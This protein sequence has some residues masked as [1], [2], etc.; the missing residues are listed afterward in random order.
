MHLTHYIPN[1]IISAY[2]QDNEICHSLLF[3]SFQTQHIR[4]RLSTQLATFKCPTATCGCHATGPPA[5]RGAGV[6]QPGGDEGFAVQVVCQEI[7]RHFQTALTRKIPRSRVSWGS[8][9]LPLLICRGPCCRR[10]LP[11]RSGSPGPG[12]SQVQGRSERTT[13]K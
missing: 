5:E 9:P 12:D 6:H 10:H 7:R 4:T 3:L 1:R 2:Y 8:K 13:S 11:P